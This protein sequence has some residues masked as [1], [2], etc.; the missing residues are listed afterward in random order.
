MNDNCS[1]NLDV[2]KIATNLKTGKY[3][4]YRYTGIETKT[5]SKERKEQTDPQRARKQV[6]G[7][8]KKVR[9]AAKK[10]LL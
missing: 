10:L 2:F 6:W 3:I 9:E 1:F 4:V 5:Q 7:E 8:T